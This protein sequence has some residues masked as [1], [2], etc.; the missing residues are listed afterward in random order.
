MLILFPQP[1]PSLPPWSRQVC[2]AIP[3]TLLQRPKMM[4]P[5]I[6]DYLLPGAI[7]IAFW[8]L[9]CSLSK[10]REP[11]DAEGYWTLTYLSS[12]LLAALIE[13]WSDGRG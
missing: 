12:L 7:G 11:W 10:S 8:L 3:L 4:W 9:V 1:S 6:P 2:I 5:K 13:F